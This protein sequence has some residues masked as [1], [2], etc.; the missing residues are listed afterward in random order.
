MERYGYAPDHPHEIVIR[1]KL[2]EQPVREIHIWRYWD[3]MRRKIMPG[4]KG[5]SLFVVLKVDS[6]LIYRRRPSAGAKGFIRMDTDAQYDKWMTGRTVEAHVT[7]GP[8]ETRETYAVVD[9]DPGPKAEKDWAGIKRATL[10]IAKFLRGQPDLKNL[11]AYFTGSRGFQLH[12]DLRGKARGINEIRKDFEAR[13]RKHFE[14]HARIVVAERTALGNK[15]NVDLAP[16]KPNGGHVAPF[17][18]RATGLCAIPVSF[19][20]FAG[21]KKEHARMD[22]V[23]ERMTGKTFDWSKAVPKASAETVLQLAVRDGCWIV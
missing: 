16:L 13:L 18:L 10:E 21:F 11:R 2:I 23:F 12:A 7:M 3:G 9:I 4:L 19:P 15:I 5:Q 22:R 1:S 6:Q 17:S 14:G 8:T 20:A